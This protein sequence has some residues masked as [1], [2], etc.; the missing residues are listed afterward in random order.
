MKSNKTNLKY[1]LVLI[2]LALFSGTSCTEKQKLIDDT[3]QTQYGLVKGLVNEP[4]TVTAFKGIPYAAPPVGS[5]RWREPQPPMPWEG[6]R[7]A[8]GFCESCMQLPPMNFGPYTDEFVK[9]DS[10]SEDCLFLNIWTPAKNASDQLAVLV[11]IHGGGFSGGSGSIVIYDGEELAKKGIIVITINYRV[12]PLGFLSHPELTTESPNHASGNYGILDQIA[13]LKWI[14]ENIAA[15]GGDPNRVTIAGQSAGAMSVNALIASPLAK[16]LFQ[17]AIAQSGSSC[18]TGTFSGASP[19]LSEA[20]MQGVEFAKMRGASSL[21]ELRAMSAE[22]ITGPPVTSF[23]PAGPKFGTVIDGYVLTDNCLKTFEKG[24]QNDVPFMT[25]FNSGETSLTGEFSGETA[26]TFFS[27]Y[28]LG[29][30]GDTAFAKMEAA[31]EQMRLNAFL[32][33]EQRAETATTKGYIYYFDQAIP[34]PEH[35]EFGAFHTSEVLYVFRNFKTLDRPWTATDTA[36]S[37]M[38]SSYWV[39]FANSGDP[40]NEGLPEWKAFSSN[41]RSVMRLSE[42][43]GMIPVTAN[44]DRFNFLKNILQTAK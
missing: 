43:S 9:L 28:P 34:W 10:L 14:Q 4:G 24:E 27:L 6:V 12:G 13:A 29:P 39:N 33:M 37:E 17:R 15:F 1:G 16:G 7:D 36:V 5:L 22:Q 42:N 44:E 3:V 32:W 35:P 31:R 23:P 18:Y 40:N 20:E 2:I 21:A 19:E 25:G 8:S 11:Y 38:M 26:R 30:E 41:D